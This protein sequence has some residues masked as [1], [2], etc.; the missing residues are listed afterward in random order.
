MSGV[1]NVVIIA[2]NE[3]QNIRKTV[4]TVKKQDL[5]AN[6]IVI[7][8]DG[9][10]DKTPEILLSIHGIE[11]ITNPPH[12]DSYLGHPK[13]AMVRNQGIVAAARDMPDYLLVMDGDTILPRSY[14]REVIRRMLRDGAV[15]ASGAFAGERPMMPQETGRMFDMVWFNQIGGQYAVRYGNDVH[16]LVKAYI[17]GRN[18]ATYLDLNMQILRKTGTYHNP[19]REY[20]AGKARKALGLS[21]YYVLWRL[22]HAHNRKSLAPYYGMRGYFAKTDLFEP[23]VRKWMQKYQKDRIR[24]KILHKKSLLHV[25]S[26]SSTIIEGMPLR[27][28]S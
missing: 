18:T 26:R 15:I 1:Y 24:C 21:W 7:V 8:D 22:M 11:V 17:T 27:L 19:K 6:R 13:L 14:C 23:E 12:K 2:R 3:E 4:E 10:T 25:Q 28:S 20:Y 16:A 9:S 5:G